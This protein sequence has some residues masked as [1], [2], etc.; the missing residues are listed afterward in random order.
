MAL[1]ARSMNYIDFL[2]F[3]YLS[4]LKVYLYKCKTGYGLNLH[5]V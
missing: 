5:K 2:T 3:N 4:L 1:F